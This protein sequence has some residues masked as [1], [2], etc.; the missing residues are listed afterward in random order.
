M[1]RARLLQN[2]S[3]IRLLVHPR[4]QGSSGARAFAKE[5]L[6]ELLMLNVGL[7]FRVVEA[8]EQKARLLLQN[9]NQ[10]VTTFDVENDSPA[11]IARKLEFATQRA[12]EQRR[13]REA[14]GA[15]LKA[16]NPAQHAKELEQAQKRALQNFTKEW[17]SEA[18]ALIHMYGP[19]NAATRKG[20]PVAN[21]P[22]KWQSELDELVDPEFEKW[23]KQAHDENSN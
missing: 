9:V 3:D 6:S 11:K 13:Q 4:A 1:W 20:L 7:N 10:A 2:F 5:E 19:P 15:V 8:Q 14:A 18:T 23:E 16:A 17:A 21:R 12:E 22:P